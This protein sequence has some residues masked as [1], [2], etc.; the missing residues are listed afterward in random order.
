M[1]FA[2]VPGAYLALVWSCL[3]L[4]NPFYPLTRWFYRRVFSVRYLHT[5]CNARVQIRAATPA[6][7]GWNSLW[8][9]AP[10]IASLPR[11]VTVHRRSL[12]IYQITPWCLGI[13]T[14]RANTHCF[15]WMPMVPRKWSPEKPSAREGL[16]HWSVLITY[17]QDYRKLF[18][19]N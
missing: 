11:P 19:H 16:D 7:S 4:L 17:W 12:R 2:T 18:I 6:A 5:T 1:R 3:L 14:V 15:F 13:T 9:I 8:D 10:R